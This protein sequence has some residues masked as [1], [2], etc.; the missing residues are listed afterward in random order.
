MPAKGFLVIGPGANARNPTSVG[1]HFLVKKRQ[2][3][4][5]E[6]LLVLVPEVFAAPLR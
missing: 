5:F 1:Y 6:T 2:G 3:M 4:E